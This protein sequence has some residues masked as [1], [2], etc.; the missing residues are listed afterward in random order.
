MS[1][2]A[3]NAVIDPSTLS[4]REV[5]ELISSLYAV[6]CEIFD[7]VSRD[8]FAS[9]V[10]LSRADQTRIQVS[11]GEDGSVAG[12][13]A[14]HAFRRKLRNELVTINRAEAG[15]RR[16]YRGNGS[17]ASF[18]I[19][20]LLKKRWEFPGA[21][22]YLGCLV[23]PSSYSG[24]ARDAATLWPAPG[25]EI[26]EDLHTLM[27]ELAE[28]FHLPMV[29]PQRPLVRDVGWIT[30]DTEA[31]RR[32]WQQCDRPAPRFYV[33]QNP[34]YGQGHGLLTLVPLDAASLTR[35]TVNWGAGRLKKTLQRT[36][37]ALERSVLKPRLDSLSAEDLLSTVEEIVGLNLDT[38]RQHGLLG[39]RY[40]L[41]ARGVLFR[42]GEAADAMYVV[43]EGSLFILGRNPE[44]EELVIDQLGPRSLVGELELMTGQPRATTV[45]AAV[46][47]V[48]LRL[49]QEDIGQLLTAEP[50]LA[51]ELWSR[52]CR[53][54]FRN[55][56]RE[57]PLYAGMP[58]DPQ[59]AWFAQGTVYSLKTGATLSLTRESV[60]V[61]AA[62]KLRAE[63][64]DSF[65][66]V[67]APALL[68][69][70]AGSV[71]TASIAAAQCAVLPATPSSVAPDSE[72]SATVPSS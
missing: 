53:S 65:L 27:L 26:P 41:P 30:R 21:Q 6:H 29:D 15:L 25:V 48:L 51:N 52:I 31:E 28:E 35:S 70:P 14:A 68:K 50:R 17:P 64:A 18:L 19:S 42:E 7:G 54:V 13:I 61:L 34:T 24:F 45:R 36:V 69:L 58:G 8:E 38:V 49:T 23:H 1:T 33:E 22:Y 39:T 40:P 55:E 60:V 10:I 3:S 2:I 44:G 59:D 56:L 66:S 71:L 47:T 57:L 63:R 43:L 4:A 20:W 12:Y 5:D 46:D 11:Y 9:Y 32:Y 37:G 62:G 67:S 72:S 16:P